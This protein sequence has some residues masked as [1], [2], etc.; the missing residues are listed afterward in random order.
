V[1]I[2]SVLV[3]TAAQTT[4]FFRNNS[5]FTTLIDRVLGSVL[6]GLGIRLAFTKQI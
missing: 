5:H 6:I 4:T 1:I 3:L 2:E